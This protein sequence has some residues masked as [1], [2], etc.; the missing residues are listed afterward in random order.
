MT[1]D[2]FIKSYAKDF[3]L[4]KIA[5]QTITRNV[6]GYNNLVLLIPE[7]DR[8]SF[9]TR[10]LPPRTLIYY[11]PDVGNGWLRQQYFKMTAYKYCHTEYIMFSDSDC[12]FTYPINLQDC[13]K[14]NKPEIL[15]TGWEKVGDA[16]CWK[17]PT[18]LF[19]KEPVEWEMMRRNQQC[20]HRS[21]LVAISEFEPNV[22]NIIMGSTRFSEFN[23][24]S[25]YCYKHEKEKYTFVNT[26][27]WTYV[28]PLAEQ[29]W[30]HASKKN[31]V[32]EIHLREWIRILET[33]L[34]AHG[35]DVPQ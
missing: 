30:S 15:Y 17:A 19:L 31:D 4:L 12:F 23:T 11:V 6:T 18:E 3:W 35:I 21:T 5:L 28:P 14:D 16:L 27:D 7:K 13:I 26:A 34:K 22:E 8:D 29:V 25:S 20:Y 1:I 9:D 33:I 32:S 2:I 24:M 10:E